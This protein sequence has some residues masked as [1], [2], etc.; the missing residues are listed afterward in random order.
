VPQLLDYRGAGISYAFVGNSALHWAAA[1]GHR[2]CV[3][4]L[5]QQGASV[6]A[7][8]EAGSTA[9]H[10]AVEHQ[11]PGC[12]G[13]LVLQGGADVQAED[14]YGQRVASLAGTRGSRGS[15]SSSRGGVLAEQLLLWDQARKLQQQDR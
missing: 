2:A 13:V 1:K 8:N 7:V 14:G 4:W 15:S 6:G 5:L 9:L 11:Q 10:T 12:A 3:M